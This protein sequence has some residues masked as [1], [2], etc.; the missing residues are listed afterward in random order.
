MVSSVLNHINYDIPRLNQTDSPPS[1]P[2]VVIVVKKGFAD[3]G[4]FTRESVSDRYARQIFASL[5]HF[6]M[7]LIDSDSSADDCVGNTLVAH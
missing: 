1:Q 4:E 6:H 7:E 5:Y 2:P 3:S